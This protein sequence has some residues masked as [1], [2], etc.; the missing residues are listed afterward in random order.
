M[1]RLY[2]RMG[3]TGFA[4][5]G[6]VVLAGIVLAAGL[7]AFQAWQV[8]PK[9]LA[10]VGA[11][12]AL[13]DSSTSASPEALQRVQAQLSRILER[14]PQ[15]AVLWRM[16]GLAL[17][18]QS[19]P[20]EALEAWRHDPAAAN[21]LLNYGL[22]SQSLGQVEA[23]LKWY[24]YATTLIP[25]W[26]EPW[27]RLATVYEEQGDLPAAEAHIRQAVKYAPDN[28]DYWFSLGL[29]LARRGRAP[30][31]LEAYEQ[32]TV[33]AGGRIGQSALLYQVGRLY[34]LELAPPDDSMAEEAY[35]RAIELDDFALVPN[36]KALTY[37]RLGEVLA[38][39]G[40]YSE[41]LQQYELALSLNRQLYEAGLGRARALLELGRSEEAERAL[42]QMIGAVPNR[43]A[44]YW[45]LAN[46]YE[47]QGLAEKAKELRSQAAS[48]KAD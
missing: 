17:E 34:E 39:R 13:T 16:L 6:L 18:R 47:M 42:R 40:H 5:A 45:L 3:M 15:D 2:Q 7:G 43:P 14:R 28:R 23:A 12:H 20:E 32:G 26:A 41:A 11:A 4:P 30:L 21:L 44:A 37:Y 19:Q 29:L 35:A 10:L 9:N 25:S 22:E 46:M 8:A 24:G 36:W 48:L 27:Y 1:L 31:A 33:A 38:A